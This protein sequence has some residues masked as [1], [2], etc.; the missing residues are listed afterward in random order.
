MRVFHQLQVLGLLVRISGVCAC[1]C[2]VCDCV[3]LFVCVVVVVVVCDVF[4][5]CLVL[6]S[7]AF[8]FGG[9][10]IVGCVPETRP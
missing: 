5:G 4:V 6:I 1:V 10:G 8:V 2:C 9:G 7:G 3:C